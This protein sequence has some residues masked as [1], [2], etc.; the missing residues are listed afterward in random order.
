MSRI[1]IS[2]LLFAFIGFA[3]LATVAGAQ[4]LN[5]D[6]FDTQEEA[7]ANLN[8][9][10]S[11]PNGLD[12]DND[13]QACDTFNYGGGGGSSDGGSDEGATDDGEADDTASDDDGSADDGG[14]AGDDVGELPD[15]GSGPV[16]SSQAHVMIS[17]LIVGSLLCVAAA[18][19]LRIRTRF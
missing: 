14:N 18:S 2:A 15:T 8:A 1:L 13:G 16:S 7:Q 19:H 9:N 4:N 17:L 11:D 3:S 5:C 12:R 10:P 6:D